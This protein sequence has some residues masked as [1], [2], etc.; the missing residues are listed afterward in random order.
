MDSTRM[1]G[2]EEVSKELGVSKGYAYRLIR[3]LNAE[4]RKKGT[5]VLSGK[6]D[7]GY[8]EYHFFDVRE[9]GS[10]ERKYR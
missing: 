5:I 10:R 4:L 9:D 7:R 3:L 6:V 8:F 2:A 1:I